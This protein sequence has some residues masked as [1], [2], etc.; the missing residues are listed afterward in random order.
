[1]TRQLA[2]GL[3]HPQLSKATNRC[4]KD[5]ENGRKNN[6]GKDET[7]IAATMWRKMSKK[8]SVKVNT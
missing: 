5:L 4:E 6:G 3:C 8:C 7:W 2:V 1:M